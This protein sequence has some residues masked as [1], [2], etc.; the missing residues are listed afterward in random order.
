MI[1][2]A[3]RGYASGASF[4]HDHVDTS[5]WILRNVEREQYVLFGPDLVA[6]T[7]HT[8]IHTYN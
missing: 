5:Y 4:P 8:Y 6:F 1:Q 3:T 7:I 2:N